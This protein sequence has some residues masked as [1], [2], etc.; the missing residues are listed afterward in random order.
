MASGFP[1]DPAGGFGLTRRKQR[2]QSYVMHKTFLNSYLAVILLSSGLPVMAVAEDKGASSDEAAIL[3]MERDWATLVVKG[4]TAALAAI[5][6]DDCTFMLPSGELMPLKQIIADMKA[7]NLTYTSMNVDD[8]KV[9]VY[10]NAAVV[11]GLETEKSKYKNEDT[12][13]QYRFVDTWIRKDGKWRCLI[14]ANT[15]MSPAK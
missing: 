3:K 6:T 8:L 4:E 5:G 13:G 7:G 9:H 10:G 11:F 1:L 12:S 15:K 2:A 14:S